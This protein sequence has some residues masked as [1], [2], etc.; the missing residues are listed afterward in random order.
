MR[1]ADDRRH[2]GV[3]SEGVPF[4]GWR[5]FPFCFPVFA[6]CAVVAVCLWRLWV[7]HPVRA[8]TIMRDEAGYLA[9]AAALAGYQFD[10]A[11]SYHAGYSLLIAPVVRLFHD[12]WWIYRAVQG[13]NLA[14]AVLTIMAVFRFL[15]ELEPRQTRRNI[16]LATL[17]AIAYPAFATF[18]AFSM[19]ENAS[20]PLF[21]L[22]CHCCLRTARQGGLYWLSWGLVAGAMFV[23]HP[24][25]VAAIIAGG[26]VGAWLAAARK[27]WLGYLS[28]LL[29]AAACVAMHQWLL[30]PWLVDRLTP[31]GL[32]PML[33]YPSLL[34][35]FAAVA[36]P[37]GA[38]DLILR[39][40]GHAYYL[41][42]GTLWLSW[43][44]L[45]R[46]VDSVRCRQSSAGR[47]DAA[48]MS[49]IVLSVA[50]TACLSALM[51]SSTRSLQQDHLMY[52]RYVE[53]LLAP[54]LAVGFL[55][56]LREGAVKVLAWGFALA[57]LLAVALKL[58][59]TGSDAVNRLNVTALWQSDV[60]RGWEPQW[61]VAMAMACAALAYA[62]RSALVRAL[63]IVAVFLFAT[64]V[65]YRTYIVPC[66][67]VFGARN[68]IAHHV[69]AQ[70]PERT[71]C[72]G[73]D[74]GGRE[75]LVRFEAPFAKFGTQ[76]FDYG[77][78]RMSPEEWQARCD[79]P[80]ISWTHDLDRR[81][82]GIRLAVAEAR[83]GEGRP[84]PYLWV[85]EQAAAFEVGAGRRVSMAA[86][87]PS[88]DLLLGDGWH[89]PEQKGIWSSE[90]GGL[91][92]PV[93]DDCA[94]GCVARL[95][96]QPFLRAGEP[97]GIEVRVE[98]QVVDRWSLGT[99][100]QVVRSIDL[101]A[102]APGRHEVGVELRMEGAISPSAVGIPDDRRLG[103]FLFDVEIARR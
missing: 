44:A 30:R 95:R 22:A 38:K 77:I 61:W 27:E 96:F 42:V 71:H 50:G 90:Q 10:G 51:F 89:L 79:G 74:S 69:R 94:S 37:E 35:L 84:G 2:R 29:A 9:N 85:R 80:L 87:S 46:A 83:D 16:L 70:Y 5:R 33:H 92:L 23:V 18:S 49:F 86:D 15:R 14:L 60:L 20:I 45:A 65:T 102:V 48:T 3:A 52:G 12:P 76:L 75:G 24:V 1:S 88:R 91:Y 62:W 57:A 11:S 63:V 17:V 47:P 78:R 55:G 41:L 28:F 101:P 73:V 34:D 100:A 36:R 72:L 6:A 64:V 59:I 82:P 54:V 39:V 32:S 103:I 53:G 99:S 25:G 97:L 4:H 93:P 81:I 56:A 58:G 19:S 43:F 68:M 40:A 31:A 98:G 8:A 7:L 26:L 66:Y 67:R 21:V 13:L